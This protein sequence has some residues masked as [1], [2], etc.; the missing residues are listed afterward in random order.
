MGD[1]FSQFVKT[2]SSKVDEQ[3]KISYIVSITNNQ[4]DF[5]PSGEL[6]MSICKFYLNNTKQFSPSLEHLKFL[7]R[8]ANIYYHYKQF[9]DSFTLLKKIENLAKKNSLQEILN[10]SYSLQALLAIERGDYPFA[11]Q[12]MLQ[13]K[14]IIEA[15]N[16]PLRIST[17]NNSL[18]V[19]YYHLGDLN[20]ALEYYK[21]SLYNKEEQNYSS[22]DCI[23]LMNIATIYI[24]QSDL[25][26]AKD[27]A[28]KSLSVAEKLDIGNLIALTK[29][30]L[31]TIVSLQKDFQLGLQL[32]NDTITYYEKN[33]PLLDLSFSYILRAD[34]TRELKAPLEALSDLNKAL[35]IALQ[36]NNL[37]L[38]GSI[39]RSMA[40]VF[41][42]DL[43][44]FESA[45]RYIQRYYEIYKD[46]EFKEH[47]LQSHFLYALYY[48]KSQQPKKALQ[49]I[50]IAL[51]DKDIDQW[52]SCKID[53]LELKLQLNHFLSL[54]ERK[55]TEEVLTQ[56]KEIYK[57][58]YKQ[59]TI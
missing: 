3:E 19:I 51:E 10:L 14:P 11:L 27:Y 21:Q 37:N 49:F 53:F 5:S 17:L 40:M 50:S 31:S 32:A 41:L 55:K 34:I 15:S 44:K 42:N 33:G 28:L 38:E 22:Q 58:S 23:T 1:T 54:S 4:D 20:Q 57:N 48:S 43:Q 52:I 35:D 26:C 7:L 6:E 56:S 29:N 46:S 16:N 36:L 18:G 25:N 47:W 8:I 2:F 45:L 30:K 9:H 13:S 24:Q 59:Q 12:S 39:M